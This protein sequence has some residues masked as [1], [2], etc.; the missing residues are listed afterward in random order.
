MVKTRP[1][2]DDKNNRIGLFGGTF[3]PPHLAHLRLAEEVACAHALS[4]IVFMPS[5]IPPHKY[6][7]DIASPQDR[8]EMTRLACSGNPLFDVSDMEISLQ[9]PSYTVN[10]LRK[11]S[12]AGD[13]E[14]FFLLGSDSLSEISAWREYEKLF[15]LSNFIV[16]TRPEIDFHSAWAEVPDHVRREF[17]ARGDHYVHNSR[18]VL[19]PSK[20]RGLNISSTMIRGLIKS[21][22]SIRYLVTEPVRSYIINNK[23]YRN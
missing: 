18:H 12:S 11:L 14:F 16:I 17:G 4:K 3:N 6:G 22:K 10:T 20:V 21:E 13:N 15:A 9:G 8:L 19:I 2:F 7:K 1:F 5:F 23:L